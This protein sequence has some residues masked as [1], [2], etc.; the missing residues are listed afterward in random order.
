MSIEING[1]VHVMLT[2]SRFEVARALYSQLLAQFGMKVVFDGAGLFYCVGGRTAIGI[3][4][5]NPAYASEHFVQR[6]V[7]LHHLCLRARSREDVDRLAEVLKSA[8][9]PS[10]AN[11]GSLGLSG[12]MG[13]MNDILNSTVVEPRPFSRVDWI[14]SPMQLSSIVAAR[15]PWTVPAGLR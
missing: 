2:V 5:C 4:P 6:R 15:P 13:R 7:G 3:Q 14:A 8:A 11:H 10:S 9:P 1:M 12:V